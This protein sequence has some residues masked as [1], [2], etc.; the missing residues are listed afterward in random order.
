MSHAEKCPVC[1]GSGKYE[2][3]QCHG[4][5]GK[6][7]VTVQDDQPSGVVWWYTPQYVPAIYIPYYPEYVPR[8]PNTDPQWTYT[9]EIRNITTNLGENTILYQ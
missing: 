3:A 5:E 9:A 8:Y 1:E 6:G 2:K 7:W 4:C